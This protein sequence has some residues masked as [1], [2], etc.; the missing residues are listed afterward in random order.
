VRVFIDFTF[1]VGRASRGTIGTG[2]IFVKI[3]YAVKIAN[4]RIAV[5]VVAWRACIRA[6]TCRAYAVVGR[7][8]CRTA[9][10]TVG[11][12]KDVTDAVCIT[13][14]TVVRTVMLIFIVFTDAVG[15]AWRRAAIRTLLSLVR[16]A[17]RVVIA[18]IAVGRTCR[19]VFPPIANAIDGAVGAVG[20]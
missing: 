13:R 2:V 12:F 18:V 1:T 8:A 19:G 20:A 14:P 10:R 4:R 6:F 9:I 15:D 11:I 17:D 5:A 7:R 3:A 16:V